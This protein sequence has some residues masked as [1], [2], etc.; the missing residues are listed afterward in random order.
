MELVSGKNWFVSFVLDPGRKQFLWNSP[1]GFTVNGK[2]RLSWWWRVGPLTLVR[3]H[4][5]G[6]RMP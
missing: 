1:F 4:A 6:G 2:P 5:N 3:W